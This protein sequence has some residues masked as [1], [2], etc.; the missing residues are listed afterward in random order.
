LIT[1]T[2]DIGQQVNPAIHCIGISVNTS[3]LDDADRAK[4]LADV[5][6]THHVPAVDPLVTGVGA[7]VDFLEAS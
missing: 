2:V 6:A 4:Y 7:I 3:A 5:A 1:R